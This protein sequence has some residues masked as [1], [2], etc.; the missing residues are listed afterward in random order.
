MGAPLRQALVPGYAPE[1]RLTLTRNLNSNFLLPYPVPTYP[2]SMN[3]TIAIDDDLL[4]R[5]RELARR[6]GVSLQELIRE[7]LRTLAGEQDGAAVAEELLALMTSAGGRSEGRP[8]ARADAYA[9]R[10]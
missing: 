5:A 9:G 7:Q 2:V 3:L 6:R 8:W 4:D 1:P 10:V